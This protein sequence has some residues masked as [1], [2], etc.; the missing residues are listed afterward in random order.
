MKSTYMGPLLSA[1]LLLVCATAYAQNAATPA[2]TQGDTSSATPTAP[3]SAGQDKSSGNDM[4]GG[5]QKPAGTSSQP[6]AGQNKS[7][8]N[9]MVGDSTRPDFK[10]LDTKNNGYVTAQDVKSNKW[11]SKN[12]AKCDTDHDGHLSQQEYAKCH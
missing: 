3:H 8:G 1:A 5:N 4:V 12:F 9:D 11:L 7:T 6:S 2:S 10:T